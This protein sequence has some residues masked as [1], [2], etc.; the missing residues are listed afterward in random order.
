MA[1]MEDS[2][3][4]CY[5]ISGRIIGETELFNKLSEDFELGERWGGLGKLLNIF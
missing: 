4:W 2:T 5:A 1:T 3:I